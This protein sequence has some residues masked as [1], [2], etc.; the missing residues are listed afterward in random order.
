M[1]DGALAVLRT[2]ARSL[3]AR[4]A[5]QV[6]R[7]SYLRKW[8]LLG[9]LLGVVAGL[10]AVVF[11]AALS[12]ATHVFLGLIVGYK[13]PTP[14]AEGAV[15]G[16]SHYGRAWLLPL[17]VALGGL[18]S[19][20]IVFSLAPEAEGHGTDAAIS[21]VHHNP[22]G[23]RAR[24]V[25]VKIVASA[26]TIG[27]G[28]S[29]GREGPTAQI[30]A[31]FG[32]LLA[33]VLDLSPG[34]GRIAVSVGIG[35]GI[36]S[37]FGAPLG[38]ALL[39]AELLYREDIEV[40]AL[41]PGIIASIV[42]YT[43][44]SAFYGFQPLFGVS[45]S[46]YR[47][48]EPLQLVWFVVLGVICGFIGLSYAKGFYGGVELF[49]RLPVKRF[50]R[51]AIGGLL[52]GLIALVIPEVLGTGYGWIQRG[53]GRSLLSIPL[54][55]VLVLPL[56]KILATTLSIG[57]GG[58]GGIFGPGMV[59]GAF[60]GAAVWRLLA[61][62]APSVPHDPASFVIVGMMA[63]FGS[64]ARAPLAVMIMVAEMTGSFEVIAPAMIAVGI[65]TLIVGQFDDT[66][67]RS[68]LRRRSDQPGARLAVGLPLLGSISVSSAMGEATFVLSAD[69]DG[70]DARRRLERE[71]L[72]GAPVVDG[73]GVYVGVCDRR[74][75]ETEIGEGTS[76][77]R[78]AD[79]TTPSITVSASLDAGLEA[80][81]TAGR[82]W[83]PVLNEGKEVIGILSTGDIVRAH[84]A[85]MQSKTIA[86]PHAAIK[87]VQRQERIEEAKRSELAD[88][89]EEAEVGPR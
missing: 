47:F 64:I 52:V 34:D 2:H 68:Q 43:V 62:I 10:G 6:G 50:L 83:I 40:A 37:I 39:S 81:M 56:A 21:T 33:R 14:L 86:S 58:S 24:T 88:G 85:A 30:S 13:V 78:I 48:H 22:R 12:F 11:Y 20:I 65:A 38:G 61:P 17:V 77:G 44:F 57:S 74:L 59:I 25:L 89:V 76:V 63:C 41:I 70:R 26:L 75:D 32:S 55:I 18:L 60:A 67:Y 31:G 51:P 29:G 72:D 80:L 15:F 71:G 46:S 27:S 66:I 16:S 23:A 69:D 87:R 73:R 5:Y 45:G 3:G 42:G 54:W 7:M 82:D 1:P 4:S 35:S 49:S 19:G 53:L 8:L 79:P 9:G 36:G 28:G 84:Q